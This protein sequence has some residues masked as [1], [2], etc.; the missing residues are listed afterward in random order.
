MK[1]KQIVCTTLAAALLAVPALAA[2]GGGGDIPSDR[3]MC[4][5]L[6]LA[7]GTEDGGA[8]DGGNVFFKPVEQNKPGPVM[9][10]GSVTELGEGRVRLQNDNTAAAYSDIVLTVGGDTAILDAVTGEAKAFGDIRENETLYAYAGPAMTMS[11][12]PVSNA[13]LIL[14][15]VPADLGAPTFA[16]VERVTVGEDGSVSALMSGGIVLHLD[17]NTAL[18]PYLTKNVAGLDDIVPGAKLLSWYDMVMESFPAQ[19][20][21]TKVMVFP[22][23]Y[24]GYVD[25]KAVD[26]IALNGGKLDIA[27][28]V[29]ED[30]TLMLPVRAFAEAQ[31]CTVAWNAAD[32][33]LVTVEKDGAAVYSFRAGEDA[34]TVE[35]DMVMGL[36]A[37]VLTRNNTTYLS[38]GDLVR[39]HGLKL[40]GGWPGS[41]Q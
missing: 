39:F 9:V 15:N 16:E 26:D 34:A 14:C 2:D 12:P 22:Y 35:G 8:Q 10:Y 5:G 32:P 18:M 1:L 31:G 13:V 28:V 41:V 20:V 3:D 27:P 37:P 25:I 17:E 23:E 21:P 19:A 33:A 11:L 4:V 38:A 29:A 7:P 24:T 36:S 40:V 30:G 6:P